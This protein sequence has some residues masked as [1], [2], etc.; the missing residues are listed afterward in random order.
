MT[1][2]FIEKMDALM[3]RL[4]WL[5]TTPPIA[6]SAQGAQQAERA[7]GFSLIF[8]GVRCILQYAVLPFVLPL[9]GIASEV[10]LPILLLINGLAIVAIVFSLRRF[11]RI[12]YSHRWQY[13][14]VAVAALVILIAFTLFDL[15]TLAQNGTA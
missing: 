11:W 7:F 3:M 14:I 13:L 1:A 12:R 4:L 2:P 6:D 10:A 5:P 9:I 8:S 15:Q